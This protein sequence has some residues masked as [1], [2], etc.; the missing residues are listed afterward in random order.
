MDG[1][2]GSVSRSGRVS[3]VLGTAFR[4]R[5]EL[6]RLLR[7]SSPAREYLVRAAESGENYS[8]TQFSYGLLKHFNRDY[9]LTK[10][11]NFVAKRHA[12]HV[13]YHEFHHDPDACE[14]YILTDYVRPPTLAELITQANRQCM[15]LTADAIWGILG[16]ILSGVNYYQQT[17]FTAPYHSAQI[18][19]GLNAG[20]IYVDPAGTIR[21]GVFS[22]TTDPSDS[23]PEQS[24]AFDFS[25]IPTSPKSEQAEQHETNDYQALGC[26]IFELKTGKLLSKDPVHQYYTPGLAS[27]A[28][29]QL[30]DLE[31]S[32]DSDLTSYIRVLLEA[33][34]TPIPPLYSLVNVPQLL[35]HIDFVENVRLY[36][37]KISPYPAFSEQHLKGSGRPGVTAGPSYAL[38]DAPDHRGSGSSSGA[39]SDDLTGSA[40][41]ELPRTSGHVGTEPALE[42]DKSLIETMTTFLQAHEQNARNFREQNEL[43]LE[44]RA[45][46][47]RQND[48]VK[49][50]RAEID[51]LRTN[52]TR[53]NTVIEQQSLSTRALHRSSSAAGRSMTPGEPRPSGSA[54]RSG[55][56]G[57]GKGTSGK[58]PG[59]PLKSPR[60]PRVLE[61][62][63]S[64]RESLI[65]DLRRSLETRKGQGKG[66]VTSS[67]TGVAGNKRSSMD[68]FVA[69]DEHQVKFVCLPC[70]HLISCRVQGNKMHLHNCPKCLGGIE[71]IV[72]IKD[73]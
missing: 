58:S 16:Q 65:D 5:Y 63:G 73:E 56:A 30:P 50:M 34:T 42:V 10:L 12:N 67:T 72:I 44:I 33:P 20:N 69:Q 4:H 68:E 21:V 51:A 29:E 47:I 70:N 6:C 66:S 3:E 61:G 25:S 22:L 40:L 64:A 18:H 71:N 1:S 60:L 54:S 23:T 38:F 36:N 2:S 7:E 59:R 35:E 26:I 9:T 45:L 11:S 55:R 43:L 41:L 48:E 39:A 57:G 15:Q 37:A 31:A 13:C 27:E 8:C 52:V 28:L 19:G 17:D 49:K 32:D 53:I 14:L 24:R 62:E 46:V